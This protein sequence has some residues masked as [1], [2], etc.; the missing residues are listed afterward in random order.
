MKK[1]MSRTTLVALLISQIFCLPAHASLNCAVFFDRELA[2]LSQLEAMY[3]ME[4]L[5]LSESQTFLNTAA[6]FEL[7]STDL[8]LRYSAFL[9]Y[10]R[11]LRNLSV[12]HVPLIT[13]AAIT[14]KKNVPIEKV[15][16]TIDSLLLKINPQNAAGRRLKISNTTHIR[17]AE[18]IYSFDL[19]LPDVEAN[20]NLIFKEIV[21]QPPD[22]ISIQPQ[23]SEIALQ[24]TIDRLKNK[25][26]SLNGE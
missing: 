20:Y 23:P 3:S 12:P 9:R 5:N 18:A 25:S 17:L 19:S 4:F 8:Y 24:K 6:Q 26:Q 7:K 21:G 13:L 1:K 10:S 14:L 11:S 2:E 15:T 22:V 16:D